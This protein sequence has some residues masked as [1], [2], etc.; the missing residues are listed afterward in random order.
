MC[1]RRPPSRTRVKLNRSVGSS[2]S[3]SPSR[4]C[5]LVSSSPF[6]PL[7]LTRIKT[8]LL[9]AASPPL[10]PYKMRPCPRPTPPRSSSLPSLHLI[11]TSASHTERRRRASLPTAAS[12]PHR[13]SARGK[14]ATRVPAPPSRLYAS[15]A[16]HRVPERQYGRAPVNSS[17]QPL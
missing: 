6:T 2:P 3:S 9:S 5:C 4:R 1:Q 12:L 10:R 11:S 7:K 16:S 17:R 8:P 14:P 15:V 13:P